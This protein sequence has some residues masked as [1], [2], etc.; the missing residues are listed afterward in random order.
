MGL[1]AE[2]LCKRQILNKIYLACK[3]LCTCLKSQVL[4]ILKV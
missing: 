3:L 1:E 2:E 4:R